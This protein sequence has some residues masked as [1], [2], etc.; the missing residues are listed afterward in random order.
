MYCRLRFSYQVERVG[1]PLT[2]LTHAHFY[3]SPKSGPRI[4]T[5]YMYVKVYFSE[6]R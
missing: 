3:A 1:I 2:C 5:S 6:Y 4:P